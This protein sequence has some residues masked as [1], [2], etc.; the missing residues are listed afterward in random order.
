MT[1]RFMNPPDGQ[2]C[3]GARLPDG[4]GVYAIGDIHGRLDLLEELLA[5][6]RA[7]AD[8]SRNTLVFLGDYIDRGPRS[9]QVIDCLI[10]LAW[11]GWDFVALRGNHEQIVL[12]FLQ[13]AGAYD[14]W[15]DF[16]G[17]ET[18]RSYGVKP[19][20][21]R[22][23]Y[24]RAREEFAAAFPPAHLAFFESLP[25]SYEV[26]EYLFV[27]AGVRPGVAI[28]DQSPEDMLW[29]R[30][31][32]LNWNEP[33]EK[34]VVHGHSPSRQPVVKANRIGVDTGAFATGRLTA[35]ALKGEEVAFLSSAEG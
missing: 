30:G 24:A 28:D 25:L 29:I 12:D 16:G 17:D 6:I 19:P 13:D 14:I 2:G 23:D 22:E 10:G 35:V 34:V 33:F 4:M 7:D 3:P 31:E 1:T 21:G 18:L 11:P 32:F 8:A 26:G 9:K 15:R 27:H 5:K 20:A